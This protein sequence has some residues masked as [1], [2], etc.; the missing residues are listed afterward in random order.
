[1]NRHHGRKNKRLKLTFYGYKFCADTSSFTVVAMDN[2]A[3]VW[4]EPLWPTE[5]YG[6]ISKNLANFTPKNNAFLAYVD[7][8]FCLKTCL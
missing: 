5:V 6:R 7:S 1:L 4:P 8:K 2:N 3:G